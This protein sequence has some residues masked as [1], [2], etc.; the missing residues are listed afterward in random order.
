[1]REAAEKK[2]SER[3]IAFSSFKPERKKV[4]PSEWY[5]PWFVVVKFLRKLGFFKLEKS[6]DSIPPEGG[7]AQEVATEENT[8]VQEEAEV[9][10]VDKGKN[11]IRGST[12]NEGKE[13]KTK[14]FTSNSV[15]ELKSEATTCQPPSGSGLHFKQWFEKETRSA[16]WKRGSGD[17]EKGQQM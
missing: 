9:P 1:M 10:V 16:R 4:E 7:G 5:I 3:G 11:V 12:S 2:W 17:P 8:N 15:F 6:T 13:S 14:E